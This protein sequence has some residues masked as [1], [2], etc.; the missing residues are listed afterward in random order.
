[1]PRILTTYS[2]RRLGFGD[3]RRTGLR[4]RL[5][6]LF[7]AAIFRQL[8]ISTELNNVRRAE[9]REDGDDERRRFAV[10]SRGS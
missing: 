7:S 1:M 5:A 9:A 4:L 8:E 2:P 6:G 10:G 3:E